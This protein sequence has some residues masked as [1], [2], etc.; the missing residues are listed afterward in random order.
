M[1]QTP[2][3]YI[4]GVKVEFLS[5]LDK[6]NTRYA[7]GD[8]FQEFDI[9]PEIKYSL[10]KR[11]KRVIKAVDGYGYVADQPMA[12]GLESAINELLIKHPKL[13]IGLRPYTKSG[14]RELKINE[15]IGDVSNSQ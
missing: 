11:L 5:I 3:E 14:R 9:T 7:G 13:F 6:M 12:D 2:E 8:E 4:Q 1:E 10:T 15:I